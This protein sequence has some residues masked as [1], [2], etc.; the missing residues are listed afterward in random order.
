MNQYSKNLWH[1]FSNPNL[2]QENEAIHIVSSDGAYVTDDQGRTLLDGNAGGLWCINAGHN[3][4][5]IKAAINKQLDELV[6]YQLFNGVSHPRAVELADKLIELTQPENMRK[7]FF[8]SGGSDSIDT[9]LKIARQYH[10]L[11]GQPER[12]RFISV[13]SSYHGSH[14]G[15]TSINGADKGGFRKAYEPLLPST[16]FIDPPSLDANPWGC[17]NPEQ[18]TQHC[19]NQLVREIEYHSPRY[20][21]SIGGGTRYW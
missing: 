18:L 21:C 9:A 14:F 3:R 12:K 17:D 2:V 8:T 11:N 4:P 13:K 5:E 20:N 15:G 16:I 10:T 19:I 7:V 1:P 6:F